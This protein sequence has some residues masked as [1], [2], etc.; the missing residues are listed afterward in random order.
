MNIPLSLVAFVLQCVHLLIRLRRA[1]KWG[2]VRGPSLGS[3]WALYSGHVRHLEAGEAV[4][5]GSGN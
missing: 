4:L 1:Y 2:F 5:T 3:R